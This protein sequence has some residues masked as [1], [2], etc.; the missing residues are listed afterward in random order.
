MKIYHV[1]QNTNLEAVELLANRVSNNNQLAVIQRDERVEYTGGFLFKFDPII[2][3]I[4]REKPENLSD[5]EFAKILQVEP[6]EKMYY[7]N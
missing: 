4:F 6:F 5:Y 7:E 2:A 3:K 1:A